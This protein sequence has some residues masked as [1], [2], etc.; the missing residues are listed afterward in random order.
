MPRRNPLPRIPNLTSLSPSHSRIELGIELRERETER[1]GRQRGK[2]PPLSLCLGGAC[3]TLV[4]RA[5]FG[6]SPL[7]RGLDPVFLAL[8]LIAVP[9]SGFEV[10]DWT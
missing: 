6:S 1:R 3:E 8:A 4:G 5:K 10:L 2:P 9:F 7:L